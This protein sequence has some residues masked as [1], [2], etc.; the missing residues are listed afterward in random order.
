MKLI[1]VTSCSTLN[2]IYSSYS[3]L[4]PELEDS[5]VNEEDDADNLEQYSKIDYFLVN[6]K[7]ALTEDPRFFM[8]TLSEV[9]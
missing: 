8:L 1:P 4:F 5:G 7:Q 6:L 3:T 2:Q 9:C